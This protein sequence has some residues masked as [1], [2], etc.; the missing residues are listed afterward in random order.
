MS[1]DEDFLSQSFSL[2]DTSLEEPLSP[3][4]LTQHSVVSVE[5]NIN[6]R[7]TSAA[8]DQVPDPVVSV[9]VNINGR[10]TS[11]AEDQVPDPDPKRYI[12]VRNNLEKKHA[13]K[14][15][16]TDWHTSYYDAY[17]YVTKTDHSHVELSDGHPRLD[18][19]PPLTA[20]AIESRRRSAVADSSPGSS[21]QPKRRRLELTDLYKIVVENNIRTDEE[22]AS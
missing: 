2:L 13:I 7:E 10:E 6:G 1:G 8:E 5:V 11:V 22:L 17:R 4:A 18:N 19:G 16:F 9:A 20:A 12:E 21:T 14:V 15:N 3:T